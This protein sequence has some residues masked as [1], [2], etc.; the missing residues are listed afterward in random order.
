[1]KGFANCP[2]RAVKRGRLAATLGD[3]FSPTS[4]HPPETE[5]RKALGDLP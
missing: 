5:I 1:M 2:T 4:K 3:N